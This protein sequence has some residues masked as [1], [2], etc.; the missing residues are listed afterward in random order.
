MTFVLSADGRDE[1]VV[2]AFRRYRVYLEFVR[3]VFPPSAYALATSDWY[4]NFNDHRSPHDAWLETFDLR[5]KSHGARHEKRSL[6]LCVRLLGAY[7]DGY[8]ELRYSDVFAYRLWSNDSHRGNGDWL[9]DEL[10]LSERGNLLHE[11]EWS[12]GGIWSIEASDVALEW[13]PKI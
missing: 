11:I 2:G 1:D 6:S 4:F 9:Y 3:S 12:S 7:H 5:E 13:V 8:I 10:R